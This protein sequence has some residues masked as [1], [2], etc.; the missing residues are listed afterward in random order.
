LLKDWKN[1]KNEIDE[2]KNEKV[3]LENKISMISSIDNGETEWEIREGGTK[4]GGINQEILEGIVGEM[5]EVLIW[6]LSKEVVKQPVITPLGDTYTST[7][8]CTYIT[9][10]HK[11]PDTYLPLSQISLYPNNIA[12]EFLYIYQKYSCLLPQ[13]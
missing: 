12:Q 13:N 10:H 6:G 7:L 5:R 3:E 9:E 8:I 4:E 2:L 11:H 1:I